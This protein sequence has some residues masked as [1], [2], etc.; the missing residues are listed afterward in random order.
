MRETTQS[1]GASTGDL[2][3][4]RTALVTGANRGLGKEVCRQL[5]AQGLHVILTARAGAH[6]RAA[7]AELSRDGLTIDALALDV[8]DAGSIAAAGAAL[9]ERGASVDVLVNNAVCPGWVRTRMGGAGASRGVEKGAASIVWAALRQGEPTGGFFR[10]G[11][12]IDW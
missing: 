9:R 4:G 10:D 1:T 7:A 5:G 6:A 8:T 11:R 12:R 2:G 3:R